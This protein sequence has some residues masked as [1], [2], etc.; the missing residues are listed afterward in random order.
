[1][2]RLMTQLDA[3]L[4]ATRAMNSPESD[5]RPNVNRMNPKERVITDPGIHHPNADTPLRNPSSKGTDIDCTHSA[6]G[7][8]PGK[9]SSRA[10]VSDMPTDAA[11]RSSRI[12]PRG[13]SRAQ[14]KAT[15]CTS[16]AV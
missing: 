15:N 10:A 16:A 3:A 6:T 8:S 5:L 9:R 11:T 4:I 13:L 12:K 2:M 14:R 7:R 1:M